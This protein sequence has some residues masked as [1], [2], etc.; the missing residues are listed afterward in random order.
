MTTQRE[1]GLLVEERMCKFLRGSKSAYDAVDFETRTTMY[2][3]KSASL[4]IPS[5]SHHKY[6][7]HQ[8]GQFLIRK[9]NH[10]TLKRLAEETGKKPK[11]IFVVRIGKQV[12]VKVMPWSMVKFGEKE[13][14]KL[15]IHEVFG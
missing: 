5:V 10:E 2:E 4:F 8:L 6:R 14:Y 12:A 9:E 7:T 3:V 1:T 13:K 15:S 11:Y